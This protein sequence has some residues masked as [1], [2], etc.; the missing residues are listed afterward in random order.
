MKSKDL[1]NPFIN[2]IRK[3][4]SFTT[5]T[6]YGKSVEKNRYLVEIDYGDFDLQFYV[7]K[8]HTTIKEFKP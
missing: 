3:N 1:I 5:I 4:R 6:L 7:C 2:S 8:N